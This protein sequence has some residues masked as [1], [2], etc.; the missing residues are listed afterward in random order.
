MKHEPGNGVNTGLYHQGFTDEGD[1]VKARTTLTPHG[2]GHGADLEDQHT[3]LT[4]L[5]WDE[6]TEEEEKDRK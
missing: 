5:L 3:M 6:Q 2:D 1:V 4:P